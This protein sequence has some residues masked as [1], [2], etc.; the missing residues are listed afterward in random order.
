M[1]LLL[2]FSCDY[3]DKKK[4]NAEDLLNESLRSFNW[5]EVDEYPTFENCDSSASKDEKKACFEN[6]LAT[7][8]YGQLKDSHLIVTE[9]LNDTLFLEFEIS[10]SG[11]IDYMASTGDPIIYQEIPGID[12]IINSSLKT[13]PKVYPALKRG[14]QVKTAFKIPLVIRTD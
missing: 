4:V 10:S 14:Q 3:F 8:V 11:E 7:T 2:F 6:V 5:N 13:L 12:S 9:A 1:I